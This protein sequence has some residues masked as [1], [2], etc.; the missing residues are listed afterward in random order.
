MYHLHV[1]SGYSEWEL[2]CGS[3]KNLRIFGLKSIF[4]IIGLPESAV[5]FCPDFINFL[6]ECVYLSCLVGKGGMLMVKVS[7]E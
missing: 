3:V 1:G 4:A 6:I 5:V 2:D 7:E